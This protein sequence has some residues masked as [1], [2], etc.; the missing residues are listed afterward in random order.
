MGRTVCA[1]AVAVFWHTQ[2]AFRTAVDLVTVSVTVTN[3]GRDRFITSGVAAADFRVFEDGVEH[4]V[5][6]FSSQRLPVSVCVVLDSSGS[7]ADA[8]KI[9]VGRRTLMHLVAGLEPQDEIALVGFC[10]CSVGSGSVDPR[11]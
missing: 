10:R 6:H 2:P 7:M 11:P 1:I 3:N 5:A 4:T 8:S 9:D